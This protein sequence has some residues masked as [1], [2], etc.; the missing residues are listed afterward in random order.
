MYGGDGD[1]F[2]QAF[3]AD[4]KEESVRICAN[5]VTNGAL[6][7]F[8]GQCYGRQLITGLTTLNE[9]EALNISTE[10]VQEESKK[11]ESILE[12]L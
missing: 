5:A 4:V 8:E 1:G 2:V 3:G 9:V 12:S 7:A 11:A 10:M 6:N